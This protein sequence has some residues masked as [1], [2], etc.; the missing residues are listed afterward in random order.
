MVDQRRPP[1]LMWNHWFFVLTFLTSIL[2]VDFVTAVANWDDML[3]KH[4]WNTVPA[5]WES[6]GNTT[7]GA[8]IELHI[9]LKPDQE[10]AL[11]NALSEVSNPEHQ[12][13]VLTTP[14]LAPLFKYDVSCPFQ[15]WR[16][17]F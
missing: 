12:R 16:I 8:I 11:I 4:T 15:I 5:P 17:S 14:L 10:S 9:A 2:L 1:V 13:H 6:L 7:A 3:V